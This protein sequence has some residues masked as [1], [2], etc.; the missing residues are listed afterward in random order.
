M[1][2]L[3]LFGRDDCVFTQFAIEKLQKEH[4][5]FRYAVVCKV[6]KSKMASKVAK[7]TG[8]KTLPL[9]LLLK[10]TSS[11]STSSR[12]RSGYKK[13]KWT[14]PHDSVKMTRQAIDLMKGYGSVDVVLSKFLGIR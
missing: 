4:I 1:Y 11:R 5:P 8:K 14:E 7:I 13:I 2:L 12:R 9:M 10:S 3:Y 6:K